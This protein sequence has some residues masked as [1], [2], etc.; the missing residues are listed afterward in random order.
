MTIIGIKLLFGEPSVIRNLKHKEIDEHGKTIESGWFPFG[1]Y[2][3][4]KE[5]NAFKWQT[6]KQAQETSH[7]SKLYKS[8]AS[9][10]LNGNM[11]L[12]VQCIVGANGSGKSTLLELLYA[13]INNLSCKLFQ[14]IW[15]KKDHSLLG[16]RLS[17]VQGF[18]AELYYEIE[19]NL[20]CIKNESNGNT[21]QYSL[22]GGTWVR[23]KAGNKRN[24][25]DVIRARLKDFFYTICNNYSIYSL[26]QRGRSLIETK[27]MYEANDWLRGVFDKVDGYLTPLVINPYRDEER[28]AFNIKNE[29][30]LAKQRLAVLSL[31]F[32]SQGK[33]FMDGYIPTRIE[34]RFDPEAKRKYNQSFFDLSRK[35]L[36]T[37]IQE[38][39]STTDIPQAHNGRIF[40]Y[41]EGDIEEWRLSFAEEWRIILSRNNYNFEHY[42]NLVQET[43][44]SY[45]SYKTLKIAI[46]YPSY[47]E[48][49]LSNITYTTPKED[50]LKDS[51]RGIFSQMI[52]NTHIL[53]AKVA[54][55]D[56]KSH[57]TQ[58]IQQCLSFL[59]RNYYK[60]SHI[61]SGVEEKYA[62]TTVVGIKS[63]VVDNLRFDG[64]SQ[65][66]TYDEVFSILPPP[67]Y[68][69]EI[70]YNKSTY[71]KNNSLEGVTLD[72]MSSGEKQDMISSSY[73]MYH[74]TNLQ[75]VI[76]DSFRISYH[77][78]NLIF[79]EVELYFH[80]EFQRTYLS[81]LITMLSQCHIDEEK[82]R[83]INIIIVTHS[84]FVLSDVP[85]SNTLYLKD[86]KAKKRTEE[87]FAAHIHNLLVNQFFIEKPMGEVAAKVIEEIASINK[88]LNK[89]AYEYY[90]YVAEHVGDP[91]IKNTLKDVL[92]RYA[93]K[94]PL[95]EELAALKKRQR[96][97][98]IQLKGQEVLT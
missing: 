50:S 54:S 72:D 97:I 78:V 91:Y 38:R 67:F 70:F 73:L 87:T 25:T 8:V 42:D 40:N 33:D 31:L 12:S 69:W 36:P 58:K 57:I 98:E 90:H 61:F 3:E 6:E 79:D 71:G 96:E 35:S 84:P 51:V 94:E 29:T 82:I 4:P 68:T 81:K 18:E 74:L 41:L 80:P 16:F 47:G 64:K 19:G 9:T 48:I 10:G 20:H 1:N 76:D 45:L 26:N 85:L 22:K 2:Q 43:L 44:L 59:Q 27:P 62:D 24:Q 66:S 14:K 65:Y 5:E 93:P 30:E 7:I 89:E 60:T 95:L 53:V 92:S 15:T 28:G 56:S 46:R 13:I 83:S 23:I 39:L 32:Y 88:S 37:I 63:F 86:G 52:G 55:L 21:E 11:Q 77:H 49:L 75:S 34:Y 17:K